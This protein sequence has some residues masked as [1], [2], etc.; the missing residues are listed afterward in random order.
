MFTFREAAS[1]LRVLNV[2]NL[3]IV[4]DESVELNPSYLNLLRLKVIQ[5]QSNLLSN[6]R[7]PGQLLL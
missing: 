3:Y 2:F 4:E 5:A 7:L 6:D 1:S